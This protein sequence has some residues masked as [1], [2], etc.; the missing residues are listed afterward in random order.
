MS[1]KG[2]ATSV[3][4]DLPNFGYLT[5]TNLRCQGSLYPQDELASFGNGRGVEAF[6]LESSV[7]FGTRNEL[8]FA[9]LVH[10]DGS[11]DSHGSAD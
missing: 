3:S 9:V 7:D 6:A 11:C 5:L 8:G 10:R 1:V 4:S 2:E